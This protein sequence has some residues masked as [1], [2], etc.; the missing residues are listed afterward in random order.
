MLNFSRQ[1]SNVNEKTEDRARTV[2]RAS[3]HHSDWC[4]RIVF[5][6]WCLQ[7]GNANPANS[8]KFFRVSSETEVQQRN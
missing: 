1:P 4:V 6:E 7:V 3:P 8:L 2:K 5:F